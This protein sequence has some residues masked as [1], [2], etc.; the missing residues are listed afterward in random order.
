MKITTIGLDIAKTIFHLFAVNK[1]GKFV[2]KKQLKRSQLLAYMANLE[3]CLI[4]IR[5][6]DVL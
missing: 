2:K 1:M 4:A 6:T 3:P 5:Y